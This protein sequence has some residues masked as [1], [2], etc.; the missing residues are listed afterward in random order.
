MFYVYV[1]QM[2]NKQVYTGSTSDL[3]R[4]LREHQLGKST[5]TS[6]YLPVTLIFYEAFVSKV[7]AQRREMYLKTTKGKSAL[8]MMLKEYFTNTP[9]W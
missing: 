6:K 9:R 4:R 1:L 2:S 5:T 7:D 3:R 8:R